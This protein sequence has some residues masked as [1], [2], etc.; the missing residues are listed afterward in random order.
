MYVI[1][2]DIIKSHISHISLKKILAKLSG[3]L[4]TLY[5]ICWASLDFK[6]SFLRL[7]TILILI[8]IHFLIIIL[9]LIFIIS[10]ARS[11]YSDDEL[12]HKIHNPLFEFAL[13]PKPQRHTCSKSQLLNHHHNHNHSHRKEHLTQLTCREYLRPQEAN[14]ILIDICRWRP[15]LYLTASSSSSTWLSSAGQ[16]SMKPTDTRSAG[17]RLQNDIGWTQ[18]NF[19]YV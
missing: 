6:T 8:L 3:N 16:T 1:I 10:S 19:M 9:I 18:K 2:A 11:S 17:C 13:S 14:S 15:S 5:I 7:V 12:L 4:V